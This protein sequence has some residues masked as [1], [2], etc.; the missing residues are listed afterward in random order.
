MA[1]ALVV[2]SSS[3]TWTAV[4]GAQYTKSFPTFPSGNQS[5]SNV[6]QGAITIPDG[7]AMATEFDVTLP[8]VVVGASFFQFSNSTGQE[9][10]CAW[11]GNYAPHLPVGGSVVYNFPSAPANGPIT[12]FRFFTTQVQSG[13]GRIYYMACYA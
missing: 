1:N 7:T 13:V 4:D 11:G 6:V 3:L 5:M 10:N 12:G 8:G 2:Y 9:L